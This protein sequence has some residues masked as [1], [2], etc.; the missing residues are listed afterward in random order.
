MV[1]VDKHVIMPTGTDETAKKLQAKGYDVQQVDVSEFL[2][3]GGA[4]KCMT[5]RV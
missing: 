5:L 1:V 2:K 4:V 3:A